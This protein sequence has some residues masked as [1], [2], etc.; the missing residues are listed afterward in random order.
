MSIRKG[1]DPEDPMGRLPSRAQ[2]FVSHFLLA[3][4]LRGFRG[5]PCM[6]PRDGLIDLEEGEEGMLR[7]DWKDVERC[8]SWTLGV[9]CPWRYSDTVLEERDVLEERQRERPLSL[10]DKLR[11]PPDLA[12]DTEPWP[13]QATVT[14]EGLPHGVT[15]Q[16]FAEA[17]DRSPFCRALLA[18]RSAHSTLDRQRDRWTCTLTLQVANMQRR[19]LVHRRIPGLPAYSP[20]AYGS[21]T[22][23]LILMCW[24]HIPY[25][26]HLYPSMRY[27]MVGPGLGDVSVDVTLREG[28]RE[29]C[30]RRLHLYR[31][32][33]EAERELAGERVREAEQRVRFHEVVRGIATEGDPLRLF[34][35]FFLFSSLTMMMPGVRA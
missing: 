13:R 3:I 35:R 19:E 7:C 6:G 14:V 1:L 27:T 29:Y 28:L 9:L 18:G 25:L 24:R 4:P 17:V 15:M 10:L 5:V 8:D 34:D 20:L 16:D 21:P 30:R 33:L 23:Y 12:A 2:D 26:H 31:S 32:R 11:D 22:A